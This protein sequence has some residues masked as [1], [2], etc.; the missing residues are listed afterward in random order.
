[1]E[2][3]MSYDADWD[4]KM[5]AVTDEFHK[6]DMKYYFLEND[7]GTD[8]YRI[9]FFLICREQSLGF[10]QRISFDKK[11]K[12]LY[13]DIMLDLNLF[14]KVSIKE[15]F[16]IIRNELPIQLHKAFSKYKFKDFDS[17]RFMRDFN[18]WLTHDGPANA[19]L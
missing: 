13:I 8:I 6:M 15:K 1:M 14:R 7:Y 9:A 19:S 4:A 12:A 18:F 16:N 3:F 10:K 11:N 17:E 2:L 5:D